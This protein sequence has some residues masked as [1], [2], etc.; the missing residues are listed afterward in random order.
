[1]TNEVEKYR[2]ERLL[3]ESYIGLGDIS[4]IPTIN[5]LTNIDRDFAENPMYEFIHF[6]RQPENFAFTCRYLLGIELL[7]FQLVIL[8]EL[9]RRKFPMLIGTRGLS[10]CVTGDTYICLENCFTRIDKIIDSS[11]ALIQQQQY[12]CNN[13]GILGENGFN[14]IHYGWNNGVT[15]T[16]KLTTHMGFEIEGTL[17]HP[18]RVFNNNNGQIEW[19]ELQNITKDDITIIDRSTTWHNG[20]S[21][22][23]EDVAYLF[24]CLVGDGGYTKSGTISLTNEDKEVIDICNIAAKKIWGKSFHKEPSGDRYDYILY[25]VNARRSLFDTYGFNSSVCGEKDFPSTILSSQPNIVA[26]FIRGLMDTDGS[27]NKN[28]T[29]TFSTKSKNLI[30]TLHFA[31]TKLGIISRVVSRFNKKYNTTYYYLYIGGPSLYVYMQK[32]G[33]SIKRKRDRIQCNKICNPNVDLLPFGYIN[34]FIINMIS[35]Y[36]IVGYPI[37][38]LKLYHISYNKLSQFINKI[39]YLKH[40]DE[41]KYL[42]NILQSHYYYDVVENIQQSD[43]LTFDLH[44]YD[45]HSFITNGFISHNSWCLALYAMLRALFHQGCKIVVVG[46]AFRQSKI[47][48]EFMENFWRNAPIFRQIIESTGSVRS[49]PRRDIDRCTFV[50]GESEVTAIP[51]GTGDKIRGLRANYIL[52]DE[53]QSLAQ[54][55]FEVVIKGFASVASRPDERVKNFARI[56]VMR[57]LGYTDAADAVEEN[58]GFGNQ[59]VL[60]GTAYYHFNHFY[61]YYNRY[62][63]IIQSCGDRN[64]LEH[65]FGGEVPEAFSWK[66]YSIFRIPYNVLPKGFMD[67]SQVAQAKATQHLAI[68]RMEYDSVFSKDSEGFF[69]RSL[70]E[71]CATNPTNPIVLSSGRVEF[72]ASLV[73]AP[74][75]EYIY[76]IDPASERDNFSIV[77]LDKM[78][79]HR[80]IVYT[81]SINRQVYRE[82]L[83]NRGEAFDKSF[84]TYCAQKIRDLMRTFPT[85]HIA[86]DSQ[87][88]GVTIMEALHDREIMRPGEL[89]LWPYVKTSDDDVFWWEDKNKVTDNEV[90]LH[91]LHSINF[92]NAEFTSFA[93]HGLRKDFES[94]CV[95]FPYFDSSII[96]IALGQDKL[97]GRE[98]DTLEDCLMEIEDLKDELTTIIHTQTNAGRDKWDTPEVKLPGNKKGRL[99]KDRYSALL[100][101]NAVARV[102]E[103]SIG[104]PEYKF[105]GGYVG[106]K[107]GSKTGALYS[108]PEHIVG[109]MKGTYGRGIIRGV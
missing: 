3:E 64:K 81:W 42:Y 53:F 78:S 38:Y 36:K 33:F 18:I 65:V 68:S 100:M 96:S 6:M 97:L 77:I 88:G 4:N 59:I 10:K 48:F 75:H 69:K 34:Q 94:R 7:P 71:S 41:Y 39:Q 72:N 17:D 47:I 102:L 108:G 87:G 5:K 73:G 86:I 45:D 27:A 76:G 95:I 11:E 56:E 12:N 85:S 93:N 55:V 31:L 106:Q 92:G 35:K 90:G 49:G 98:F 20:N 46:A 29:V 51:I 99:R 109:Q 8:Q 89:L 82:R 103:N 66:D 60:S 80:R 24:G 84:Y 15:P 1:M 91:I 40:T 44:L 37:Y 54:E 2:I 107:K 28:N 30:Q 62:K 58:L 25:S 79:D 105:A 26:A 14:K 74:N 104:L 70:I 16:I 67:E 23:D 22:I 9:W 83:K 57:K 21:I 19:K 61:E 32:I 101:A 52:A 43:N 63:T 50:I 13:L